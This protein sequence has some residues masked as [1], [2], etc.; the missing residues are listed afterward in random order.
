MVIKTSQKR[1]PMY[2]I[3]IL[4]F[5]FYRFFSISCVQQVRSSAEF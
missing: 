2:H 5:L 1:A 3:I 4:W